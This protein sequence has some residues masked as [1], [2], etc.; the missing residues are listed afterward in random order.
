MVELLAE[1][2][3]VIGLDI[4]APATMSEL[5]PYVLNV[6]IGVYIIKFILEMFRYWSTKVIG[7]R[8]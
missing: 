3:G 6:F 8:F 5:I 7:G 2:F 1:F 4:T